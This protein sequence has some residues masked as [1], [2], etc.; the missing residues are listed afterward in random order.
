MNKRA[1]KLGLIFLLAFSACSKKQRFKIGA[2]PSEISISQAKIENM[3]TKIPAYGI[4][5]ERN[6]RKALEVN[7]EAGDT[8]SLRVGQKAKAFI[9]SNTKPI[10]AKVSHILRAVSSETGQSLAWLSPSRK[11]SITPGQFVTA[12]IYTSQEKKVI[13]IPK[14]AVL[15]RGGKKFVVIKS[16]DHYR[17]QEIQTGISSGKE[18]EVLDGVKAGDSVVT[19]GGIFFLYPDFKAA[20]D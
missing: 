12:W 4:V 20:E 11:S 19:Q 5:I 13:A 6:G 15:L 7:I 3:K 14:P 18:I 17:V 8:Q 16:Q 1:Q 10:S 9:G 2:L